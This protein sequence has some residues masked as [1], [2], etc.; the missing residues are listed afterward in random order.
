MEHAFSVT[1]D[2]ARDLMRIH[3]SGL[4]TP[5]DIGA[6]TQARHQARAR[7]RCGPNQHVT[8]ADI[9]EMKIQSQDAVV[10][11]QAFAAD[12]AY[13][14]RRLAFVVVVGSSLARMQ[15]TRV[16]AERDARF[17]DNMPDAEAWVFK[18]DAAAQ[19]A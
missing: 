9:R 15:A 19:A 11:F 13:R 8:I 17:F 12:P 7:L 3:L 16:A 1:V 14:A 10:Q 2:V 18:P 6:L 4:F 5:V